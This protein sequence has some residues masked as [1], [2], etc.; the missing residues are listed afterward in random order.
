MCSVEIISLVTIH[1][2]LNI[3]ERYNYSWYDSLIVGTALEAGCETLYSEDMQ[4]GQLINN[5]LRIVNPF[6]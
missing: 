5:S 3:R 6:M 1:T 4:N 2:A